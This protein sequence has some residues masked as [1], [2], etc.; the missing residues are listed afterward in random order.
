MTSTSGA[1][2]LV[3]R[4]LAPL[5]I[6]TASAVVASPRPCSAGSSHSGG[7]GSSGGP[8]SGRSNPAEP[9]SARCVDPFHPTAAR[10]QLSPNQLKA[11]QIRRQDDGARCVNAAF[12][13]ER[14]RGRPRTVGRFLTRVALCRYSPPERFSQ[15]LRTPL[16]TPLA[17]KLLQK[18]QIH[19]ARPPITPHLGLPASWL[20]VSARQG[21]SARHDM[22]AQASTPVS[23]MPEPLSAAPR[24]VFGAP[25]DREQSHRRGPSITISR[26]AGE[27]SASGPPMTPI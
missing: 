9:A 23:G 21:A 16:E 4:A 22:S 15:G 20:D 24:F 8:G 27:T 10:G 18:R 5:H 6:S 17:S 12:A 13:R 14:G 7:S 1:A 11:A 26:P 3:R 25:R 2:S 19:S